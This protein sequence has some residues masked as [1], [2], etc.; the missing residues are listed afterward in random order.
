MTNIEPKTGIKRWKKDKKWDRQRESRW[1]MK[2]WLTPWRKTQACVHA[3]DE[4]GSF[5]RWGL[6][7]DASFW[8]DA[9][10]A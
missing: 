5:S 1:A 9:V 8:T 4:R 7:L 2:E 6:R 3:C 10:Q